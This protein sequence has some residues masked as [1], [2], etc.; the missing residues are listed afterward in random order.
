MT[1]HVL[2]DSTLRPTANWPSGLPSILQPGQRLLIIGPVANGGTSLEAAPLVR[3]VT[4]SAYRAGARYVEALW[5]D[6]ALQ[7]AR[8]RHAPRDSFG[9]FSA[10]LP[11]A[12]LKHAQAGDAVLSIYA[13]DPD[14]LKN[15]PPELV[16]AVQQAAARSARPFRECISRNQT[17]WSVIAARAQLGRARV[18]ERAGGTACRASG[19]PSV[20]SVGSIDPIRFSRG[21]NISPR[22]PPAA[23]S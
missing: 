17:N 12:L 3:K 1:T 19:M 20:A 9:E 6:E 23:I 4:E 14:L 7:L 16:S 15:E 13:N 5:G 11:D 10:W 21:R 22:L 8:F 18:S 2:L